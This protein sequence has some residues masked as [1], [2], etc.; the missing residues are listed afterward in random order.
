MGY[1]QGLDFEQRDPL[2]VTCPVLTMEPA[3][4]WNSLRISKW[5]ARGTPTITLEH[6]T[7]T[8]LE[9][10]EFVQHEVDEGQ[11]NYDERKAKANARIAELASKMQ[12]R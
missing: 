5:I 2:P 12:Q 10:A 3:G 1:R 11:K 6:I 4:F 8:Q 9:L 7:H